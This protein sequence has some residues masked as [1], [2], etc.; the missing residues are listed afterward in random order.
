MTG[1]GDSVRAHLRAH[2]LPP[3]ATPRLL[4]VDD[5]ACRRGRTYGSLL[6]DLERHQVV[7]LLPDRSGDQFAAWRVDHPGVEV[8]SRD[9][10]SE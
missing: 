8:M 10:S 3:L 7:D 6:V 5:C 2:R 4:R 9:R 1:C